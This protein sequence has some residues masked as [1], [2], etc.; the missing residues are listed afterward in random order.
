MSINIVSPVQ[1]D[2]QSRSDAVVSLA[3]QTHRLPLA[4]QLVEGGNANT[5]VIS[6]FPGD[7]SIGHASAADTRVPVSDY[8]EP[9]GR[10]GILCFTPEESATI[11]EARAVRDIVQAES[12]DSLIVVTDQ[13]H[14]FRTR[15]IFEQCLGSDVDVN[16]VFFERDLSV[17]RWGWHIAYENVGFLKAVFQTTFG[18]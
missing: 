14:A 18:C 1:G 9:A 17:A 4:E 8:C 5:L 13:Y 12:W 6:Y 10:Q 2:L 7:V 3:P 11:G 15:F 16:V